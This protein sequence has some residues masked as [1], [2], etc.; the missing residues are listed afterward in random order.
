MVFESRDPHGE[1]IDINKLHSVWMV[2]E[3]RREFRVSGVVLGCLQFGFDA[4]GRPA[5]PWTLPWYIRCG[6]GADVRERNLYA[7]FA[8]REEDIPMFYEIVAGVRAV[9]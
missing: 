3:S 5:G 6:T 1:M 4:E 9:D 2:Q 8:G 7:S